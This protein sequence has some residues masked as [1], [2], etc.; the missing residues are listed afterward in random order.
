MS[1]QKN[2]QA[3]SADEMA[4][5]FRQ[6]S[7]LLKAGI[8]PADSVSIMLADAGN[9]REKALLERMERVLEIGSPLSMA[10][11]EA[12]AFS[13]YAIQMVRVGEETGRMEQVLDALSAYYSQEFE[14]GQSMRRVV[15]YPVVLA[16]I[17]AAVTFLLITKVLPV[18]QQ[19]LGELGSGIA[20][21]AA[22]LMQLGVFSETGAVVLA[23]LLLAAVIVIFALSRSSQGQQRLRSLADKLLLR[24]KLGQSVSRQRFASAMSLRLASGAEVTSAV[25]KSREL[26]EDGDPMVEKIDACL[27][28]LNQGIPFPSA[29]EQTDIFTGMEAGLLAAG[30]RAGETETV[31]SELAARCHNQTEDL[32]GRLLGRV[33]PVLILFLALSVGL[34]L[35]SVMLPLLSMMSAIGA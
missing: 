2:M 4:L 27:V 7:L 3:L 21:W 26:M 6:T 31:M 9:S 5:F 17:I 29:V 10:L 1:S 11:E 22:T 34:V 23:V 19:V 18:F 15:A 28:L 25:E 14:L 12:G 16:V 20:P 13:A 32:L 8:K 30:F 24:G 33:E 35:L